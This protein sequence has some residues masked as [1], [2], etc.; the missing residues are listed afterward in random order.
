MIADTIDEKPRL[1]A[2]DD[3]EIAADQAVAPG[4]WVERR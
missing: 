3:C 1:E 2:S 4:S